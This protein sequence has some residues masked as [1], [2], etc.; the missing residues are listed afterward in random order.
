MNYCEFNSPIGLILIAG[1]ELGL[2]HIVLQAGALPMAAKPDWQ[3][4]PDGFKD[5]KRQLAE[6][7]AGQ[8]CE[9]DLKLA[10]QGTAFQCEVWQALQGIPYGKTASYGEI[11]RAI[12]RP[13]AV[14]ALGAANGRNPLPVVIPC[15]R[16]IGANGSL[17][18]YAGGLE[19]KQTLLALE[20]AHD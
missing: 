11:A 3:H 18:G 4:C 10:P 5:A 9:F 20:H 13:K 17:T 12:G 16:V 2:R 7:F 14:R 1:D 15:H 6:Y 19:L 8:R